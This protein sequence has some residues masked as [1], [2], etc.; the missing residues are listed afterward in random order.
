MPIVHGVFL[1]RTIVPN[2]EQERVTTSYL[3]CADEL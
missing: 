1:K 2:S 3:L